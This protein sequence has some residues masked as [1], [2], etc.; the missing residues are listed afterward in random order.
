MMTI[1]CWILWIP[2]SGWPGMCGAF[3]SAQAMA[4]SMRAEPT[5]GI[6]V[7]RADIVRSPN[8]G[9]AVRGG[10]PGCAPN[11]KVDRLLYWIQRS[12]GSSHGTTGSAEQRAGM[13]RSNAAQLEQGKVEGQSALDRPRASARQTRR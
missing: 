9:Q 7:D 8:R 2:P 5:R 12:G 6:A 10:P 4:R 11:G 13:R 1:T 3:E